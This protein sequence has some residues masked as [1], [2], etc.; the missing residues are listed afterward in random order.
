MTTQTKDGGIGFIQTL[1]D[2]TYRLRVLYTPSF[3][4]TNESNDLFTLNSNTYGNKKLSAPVGLITADELAYAGSLYYNYNFRVYT[5]IGGWWWALSPAAFYAG[6]IGY[7]GFNG[8]SYFNDRTITT[9]GVRPVITLNTRA[10]VMLGD[11]SISN[12]YVIGE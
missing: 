6:M 9:G 2:S 7:S 4:C 11:G 3:K 8:N 5:H 12:P 1:Y 10:L